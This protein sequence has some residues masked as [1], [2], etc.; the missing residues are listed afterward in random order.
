MKNWFSQLRILN[1]ARYDCLS[2]LLLIGFLPIFFIALFIEIDT[3]KNSISILGH[4]KILIAGLFLYAVAIVILAYRYSGRLIRFLH[5]IEGGLQ[6][7]IDGKNYQ[8]KLTVIPN[9]FQIIFE[10]M[11]KITNIFNLLLAHQQQNTVE[12]LTVNRLA[13]INLK[14]E[15]ITEML[16]LIV[17]NNMHHTLEN[18]DSLIHSINSL[19]PLFQQLFNQLD[20]CNHKFLEHKSL[21]SVAD[22]SIIT[23]SELVKIASAQ[24]KDSSSVVSRTANAAEETEI[25]FQKFNSASSRVVDTLLFIQD[26]ANQLHLLS[27][28]AAIEASRADM[29]GKGFSIV[30]VEMKNLASEMLKATNDMFM[31]FSDLQNTSA[32]AVKSIKD[33][34]ILIEKIKLQSADINENIGKQTL[35]NVQISDFYNNLIAHNE[36]AEQGMQSVLAAIQRIHECCNDI[37]LSGQNIYGNNQIVFSELKSLANF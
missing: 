19:Q 36:G 37:N 12:N 14:N 11:Q 3:Q 10:R 34:N 5:E 17:N 16:Q 28:N 23:L 2:A 7:V 24:A 9:E 21:F 1:S 27:L 4:P 30:A 18:S 20:W 15:N 32:G 35:L 29:S 31:H 33:M 26:I 13:N 22:E 8:P 6:N 25:N